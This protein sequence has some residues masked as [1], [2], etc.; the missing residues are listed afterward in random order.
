MHE[1]YEIRGRSSPP[2]SE[3][4]RS[5]IRRCIDAWPMT[6]YHLIKG[7]CDPDG[8][9][10][11]RQH[12]EMAHHHTPTLN[13]S[14]LPAQRPRPR[15]CG[16][17]CSVERA[18]NST[19]SSEAAGRTQHGLVPCRYAQ[20]RR[21]QLYQTLSCALPRR[22]AALRRPT[23]AQLTPKR[24]LARPLCGQSAF[25]RAVCEESFG[26]RSSRGVARQPVRVRRLVRRCR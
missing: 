23:Y 9:D 6:T 4:Q 18:A 13:L 25:V 7:V 3:S 8:S 2:Y 22:R 24:D 17:Q 11:K 10:A 12:T 14:R 15:L 26:V 5:T 16:D 1:I 19:E 20:D 21:L